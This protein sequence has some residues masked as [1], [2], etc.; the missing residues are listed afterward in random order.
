MHGPP[1][2][3][4]WGSLAAV[5]GVALGLYAGAVLLL[6]IR[7][8][9]EDARMVAGFV[10]DC[11]IAVRGIVGDPRVGRGRKLLLFALLAYL[12]SPIDLVPDFIPVAG[13]LDDA[14]LLILVLR[15]VFSGGPPG[16]LRE[17]WRGP[18]SSLAVLERFLR[19]R[20]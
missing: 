1:T 19:R 12:V 9:R 20:G 16:L 2:A 14:I 4:A 7:G 8:R 15:H 17:H 18:P 3:V 10:P 13:Q 11:V 6:L 5:A